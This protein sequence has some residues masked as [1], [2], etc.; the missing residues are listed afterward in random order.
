MDGRTQRGW[1]LAGI[2]AAILLTVVAAACSSGGGAKSAKTASPNATPTI[3]D[4]GPKLQLGVAAVTEPR[5][6]SIAGFLLTSPFVRVPICQKLLAVSDAEA[7]QIFEASARQTN[8][9]TAKLT[10]VA[11][12]Q[13]RGAAVLKQVCLSYNDVKT[14]VAGATAA[15]AKTP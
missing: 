2:A 10:P 1:L 14:A 11:A 7:W 12:D 9:N 6:R 3:D 8:P 15:P 5:W 4:S 13:A